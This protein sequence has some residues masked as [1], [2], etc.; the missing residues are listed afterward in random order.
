MSEALSK[1]KLN[2]GRR[3]AEKVSNDLASWMAAV[4]L[5]RQRLAAKE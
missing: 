5:T 1:I 2:M 3:D 4:R